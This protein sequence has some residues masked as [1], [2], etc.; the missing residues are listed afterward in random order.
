MLL[1]KSRVGFLSFRWFAMIMLLP[2]TINRLDSSMS[3]NKRIRDYN[4]QV[5]NARFQRPI[6][7]FE[8]EVGKITADGDK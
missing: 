7:S 5:P 1:L 6:L 3:A 2:L 8:R 4:L